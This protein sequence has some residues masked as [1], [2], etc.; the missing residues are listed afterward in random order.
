LAKTEWR[1]GSGGKQVRPEIR[2]SAHEVYDPN[3]SSLLR[4]LIPVVNLIADM[5][6]GLKK[7]RQGTHHNTELPSMSKKRFVTTGEIAKIC[8]VSPKT[9]IAWIERKQLRSFR[10]GRGPRKV[11][12]ADL[13]DFLGSR[14]FPIGSLEELT[15]MLEEQANREELVPAI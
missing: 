12:L 8:E 1:R 6:P 11:T 9:V 13:Y 4:A 2:K 3:D 5:A 7:I 15:R 14:S 10:I